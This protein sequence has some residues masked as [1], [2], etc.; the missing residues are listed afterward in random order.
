MNFDNADAPSEAAALDPTRP[1]VCQI[2]GMGIPC[3][4]NINV[5]AGLDQPCKPCEPSLQKIRDMMGWKPFRDGF[6][7][8]DKLTADQIDRLRERIYDRLTDAKVD[9]V[10]SFK[11]SIQSRRI[12][13]KAPYK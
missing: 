8:S 3:L 7:M 12:G 11:S 13:G 1:Q 6:Y 10:H 2:P 9:T 4:A 5:L